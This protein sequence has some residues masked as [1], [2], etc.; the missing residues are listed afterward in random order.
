[1]TDARKAAAR[2]RSDAGKALAEEVVARLLAG[3]S[4]DGLELGEHDGR[5][6]LRGLPFPQPQRLRR[7]EQD[8]WFIEELSDRI[9]FKGVRLERLDLSGALL[10]TVRFLDTTLEDCRFDGARC[11]HL[12]L[13]RTQVIE[14]SFD[15]ADFRQAALGAWAGGGNVYQR[16][17]LIGADLRMGSC[18]AATF[19]GCDF[20]DARLEKIDFQSSS[21]VRCRFAGVL[22]EV[23]FYDHGFK[24][25]KPD[26]N[27]M[28]DVD[29]S[30]AVLIDVEFRRLNLD[31]VTFPKSHEHLVVHHYRC[32]LERALTELAG[33]ESSEA[34]RLL[35]SFEHRMQWAG[36][37]QRV[38]VFNL[39][40]YE[41]RGG[42]ELVSRAA[43]LL[44]RCEAVC[45]DR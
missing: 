39:L 38:G 8:E 5:V 31:R 12:G 18:P 30:D 10:D 33:D 20:A 34:R 25:G 22:R 19:I 2:W 23:T 16:V 13:V 3:R 40:D 24:T 4:L 32:A 43:N 17:S 26:P 44:R 45:A 11:Q 15:S 9:C 29:F 37:D 1:M 41:R 27:P 42:P 35:V 7:F 6:D 21:F 14:C 36:P 28:E